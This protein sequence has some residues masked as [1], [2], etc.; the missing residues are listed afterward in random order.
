MWE[1]VVRACCWALEQCRG[2]LPRGVEEKVV[3][4]ERGLRQGTWAWVLGSVGMGM[5]QQGR[6]GW[7]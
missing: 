6:V 3:F 4:V 2:R 5:G 1:E 7:T